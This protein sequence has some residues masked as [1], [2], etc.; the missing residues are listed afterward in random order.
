MHKV[1]IK[2]LVRGAEKENI[3]LDSCSLKELTE[4][5]TKDE[6]K[7]TIKYYNEFLDHL[8]IPRRKMNEIKKDKDKYVKKYIFDTKLINKLDINLLN[9]KALF[10][11]FKEKFIDKKFTLRKDEMKIDKSQ[12]RKDLKDTFFNT[13]FDS[14]SEMKFKV[15]H[16]NFPHL[17]GIR[18]PKDSKGNV[19]NHKNVSE[20]MED[21][22]Y[23]TK[24]ID[25]F[26]EHKVD[27][28]KL[29][30]FAWIRATLKYPTYIIKG[31]SIDYQK[32]NF[33]SDL[34]FIK[35]LPAEVG[36]TV[37]IVG[38]GK[39]KNFYSIMSQFP[40]KTENEFKKKFDISSR[41]FH[42]KVN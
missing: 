41:I 27:S 18:K 36:Y 19:E 22:Y 29:K 31:D 15:Y 40:I 30:S 37:H 26:V 7:N 16:N 33:M 8:D 14:D 39:E 35:R 9:Y 3:D 34:V 13:Y 4:N 32:S 23:D 12:L 10:F 42:G 38:V 24:L 11:Y 21:I 25:D 5:T 20:F 6:I 2:D 17:I 1:I 28:H